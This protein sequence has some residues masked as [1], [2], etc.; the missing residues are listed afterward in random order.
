M[1]TAWQQEV[2][3]FSRLQGAREGS[4]N[5]FCNFAMREALF[6]LFWDPYLFFGDPYSAFFEAMR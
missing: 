3:S 5:F 4:W 1:T 6:F 2:N